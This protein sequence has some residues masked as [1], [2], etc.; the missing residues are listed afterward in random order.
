MKKAE[1]GIIGGSG[2][3]AM[4]GLTNV[5]EERLTTPFGEPSDAFVLGELEGR[6]VAFL[7]RHGRG[8]RIL[9]SE[10]NF[11]ANIF[12]MKMLGV[13]S[14]LSVSA[15]GSLKEE[16]KPTDFVIP[17]QFIDRTFARAS[18]F[19]GEGIVAHVAFGDPI[20][21]PLADVLK[22]ACDT[23]GVVGKL[24][25]TYVCMEGPQ[26]S[27][28]AESNL[29]RSWGA[30]VIGMTNLQEAKLAREAEL[31]YATVAMVTDYDCWRAGHDD[32]T[33]DQ[34]VAVMH[35][36]ADNASKVVRAAVAAMPADMTKGC[37]CVDALKYAILTDRKAIPGGTKQK[38]SLLLD[39]YL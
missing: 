13:D 28:R 27:T 31:C 5:R 38:L 34:I 32:V 12:A 29:Y 10:L 22:Q 8:H 16:H 24:G 14:I 11:R 7:A 36:N 35:Q 2:L 37:A 3:Y 17:D 1:I 20:C 23:V 15:V 26:F 19:F 30:D 9:P 6:N 18:T 4:P 39:K 33:V 21:A 25:G